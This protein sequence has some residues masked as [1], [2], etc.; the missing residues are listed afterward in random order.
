MTAKQL[1][2]TLKVF[3]ILGMTVAMGKGMT[4][5]YEKSVPAL[6]EQVDLS[7]DNQNLNGYA[8]QIGV[9]FDSGVT[10]LLYCA[11]PFVALRLETVAVTP[12]SAGNFNQGERLSWMYD[13]Y[14]PTITQSWQAA[15]FQLAAWDV[16]TDGGDGLSAGRIK[17]D[18]TTNA[19]ILSAA[20]ALVATSQGRSSTTGIFYQATAGPQFSQTLFR[21]VDS[22]VP[23]PA[24]YLLLG[25][26]LFILGA[27]PRRGKPVS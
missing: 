10:E 16:V 21:S 24:T 2:H 20:T 1:G 3:G 11:D 13:F 6:F 19:N 5:T 4:M 14:A 18:S 17:A 9:R 7:F 15:A 12:L 23:E 25:A 22:S 26:G 27:L 8:G